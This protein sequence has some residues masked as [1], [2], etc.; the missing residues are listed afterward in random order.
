MVEF[1]LDDSGVYRNTKVFDQLIKFVKE[2]WG[3][4]RVIF[5]HFEDLVG[6]D[7]T[8]WFRWDEENEISIGIELNESSD[9][10]YD[11]I[12]FYDKNNEDITIFS[13]MRE[14]TN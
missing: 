9:H 3:K 5:E 8:G 10:N 12:I 7:L 11:E 2:N 4:D 1:E 6:V 14:P 13:V